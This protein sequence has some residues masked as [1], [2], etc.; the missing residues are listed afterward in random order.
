MKKPGHMSNAARSRYLMRIIAVLVE[1]LSPDEKE[2]RIPLSELGDQRTIGIAVENE[3]LI[4][5]LGDK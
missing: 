1:R 5:A 3:I 2:I 4:V